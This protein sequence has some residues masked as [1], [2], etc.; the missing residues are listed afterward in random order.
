MKDTGM[1]DMKANYITVLE[2]AFGC[3]KV[4]SCVYSGQNNCPRPP[5]RA[6][7]VLEHHRWRAPYGAVLTPL[8]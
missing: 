6:Q 5:S 2:K 3:E 4:A 7:D 8:R 1:A